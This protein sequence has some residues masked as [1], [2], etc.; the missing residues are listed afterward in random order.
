LD[1]GIAS[2]LAALATITG[3]SAAA[4]ATLVAAAVEE[5][6]HILCITKPAAKRMTKL[7]IEK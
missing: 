4:N 5:M 6:A 7:W 2:L 1:G 3:I